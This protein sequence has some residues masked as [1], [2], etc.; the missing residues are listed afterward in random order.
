MAEKRYPTDLSDQQWELIAPLLPP[1][2]SEKGRGRKREVDLREIVNAILYINRAGCSW[3]MLPRDLPPSKTVYQ[4]F[5]KW[6]KQ[7]VWQ[8][9]HQ[10]LSAQLR[11]KEGRKGT[12]T[13][14]VVDSQSVKTTDVGGAERGFD[15][16]KKIKGRKR[17]LIVDT[18]GLVIGVIVTA[19]NVADVTAARMSLTEL[20][21]K[22]PGV[23]KVWADQGYRG[24]SIQLVACGL[25]QNLEIVK[26]NSREFEVLPRR[27]VVERTFAWLMK[28]RRLSKDYERLPEISESLIEIASISLM[29]NRLTS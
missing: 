12:P 22:F 10:T 14:S 17:H 28:H 27:W 5:R 8:K 2:K 24:Q 16:N 1:A 6:Q 19:A 18:L 13:A 4:Y 7:G 29:L 3:E 11:Q 20:H 21:L 26:R 9:I 25:Q 15:G 23:E